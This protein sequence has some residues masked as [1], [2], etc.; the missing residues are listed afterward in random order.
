M[1][2]DQTH[3]ISLELKNNEMII[4]AGAEQGQAKESLEIQYEGEAL[5]INFNA[6]YLIDALKILLEDMP[7]LLFQFNGEVQPAVLKGL[8][9]DN[10]VCMLMPIKP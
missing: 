6:R 7:T 2:S 9:E 4:S 10:Y 1:A 8:N 3:V 5:S